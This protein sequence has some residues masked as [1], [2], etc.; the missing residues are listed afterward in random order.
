VKDRRVE[1]MAREEKKN[2]DE[3]EL[4]CRIYDRKRKKAYKTMVVVMPLPFSLLSFLAVTC[5]KASVKSKDR[6][7]RFFLVVSPS[8]RS[9]VESS[10]VESVLISV[11]QP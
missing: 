8:W 2:E 9:P 6:E 5:K 1:G 10:P 3:E 7:L 4:D 11:S